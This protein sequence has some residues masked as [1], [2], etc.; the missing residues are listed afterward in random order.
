MMR[1]VNAID[2]LPDDDK[3]VIT[4]WDSCGV[5]QCAYC[6]KYNIE[7]KLKL[8]VVKNVQW[9]DESKNKKDNGD[10]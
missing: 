6:F 5:Q 10:N 2:E 4:K 8:R 1:W 7:A 9:L 3:S